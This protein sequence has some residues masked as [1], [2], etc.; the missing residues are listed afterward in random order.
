MEGDPMDPHGQPRGP[1]RDRPKRRRP[2]LFI[3]LVIFTLV[4]FFILKQEVPEVDSRFQRLVNREK[5]QAGENCRGAAVQAARHLDFAR[6][7]E[8]G[9]VHLTEKGYFVDEVVVGEMN[10]SGAESRFEFSCYVDRM[11]AVI[12]THRK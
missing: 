11:G 5:W 1:R 3:F 12:K 10:D 6:I 8:N 4:A 9:T 7:I 2:E